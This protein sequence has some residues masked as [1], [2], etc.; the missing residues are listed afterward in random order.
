M[1]E[2]KNAQTPRST[3]KSVMALGDV[4]KY[5]GYGLGCYW[6]VDLVKELDWEALVWACAGLAYGFFKA[7]KLHAD[8]GETKWR[9]AKQ[10]LAEARNQIRPH[11]ADFFTQIL[12]TAR[13]VCKRISRQ[14][15]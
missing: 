8:E 13:S 14:S 11:I 15:E 7:F 12:Q 5:G 1:D 6:V 3:N 2:T 10:I 4:L 9:H